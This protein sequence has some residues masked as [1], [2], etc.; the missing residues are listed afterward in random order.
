MR[1]PGIAILAMAI[2][3]AAA[4]ARAQTY[5]PDFPIC[6]HVVE[7]ETVYDDCRY[8]TMAQCVASASGRPAQCNIN[9]YYAGPGA[10][11]EHQDRR[12]G[13]AHQSHR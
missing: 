4:P 7:I 5:D 10:L 1:I 2:M 9:P 8:Y 11:P 6:M 13:R 3:A 12:Y